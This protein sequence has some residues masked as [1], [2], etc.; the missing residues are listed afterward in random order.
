MTSEQFT[1]I[2]S[3][4]GFPISLI[5]ASLWFFVSKWW[6]W[7]S[8]R[9]EAND[10]EQARRHQA[11]LD[12][13]GQTREVFKHVIQTLDALILKLDSNRLAEKD[14]H[15]AMLAEI[16]SMRDAPKNSTTNA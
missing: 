2:V 8:E 13:M 14:E 4:V 6:P 10:A 12:E 16:R 3:T 9:A 7:Y 1:Q 15:L 5:G 11:Y